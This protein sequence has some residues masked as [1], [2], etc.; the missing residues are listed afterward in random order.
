MGRKISK[1]KAAGIFFF[2]FQVIF[3]LNSSL[4]AQQSE[5]E[6]LLRV[7]I[8]A[9]FIY[10]SFRISPGGLKAV[11]FLEHQ[12]GKLYSDLSL[13]KIFDPENRLIEEK[14]LDSGWIFGDFIQDKYIVLEKGD[15]DY[16]EEVKVVDLKGE[17]ILSIK[18]VG[19][20]RLFYDLHGRELAVAALGSD[21][22]YAPSVVYD[23]NAR[24]EKFRLGPLSFPKND[25]KKSL[26]SETR[27][28]LPVGEDNL[29]V[30]GVGATVL[31]E[32]Y[33]RPGYIWK[34]DN[35]GGNIA[36]GKFLN[37]EYLALQYF[38]PDKKY[39]EGLAII[40][41]KDG[42]V[43]YKIE[44]FIVNNR[45]E[46]DL[47]PLVIHGLYLDEDLNLNFLSDDGRALKI[48]FDQQQKT[49]D[50]K[51]K[52][53]HKYNFGKATSAGKGRPVVIKGY[54][55]H[56]DEENGEVIIKKVKL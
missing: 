18:E 13:I 21:S 12:P 41:W 27:I 39:K 8:P 14:I 9:G 51:I 22:A 4:A 43:V 28:F 31:L 54:I 48:Y 37:E 6:E 34:I 23:L 47:P 52:R 55:F 50:E 38:V 46:K 19:S 11:C 1:I 3:L 29:F 53:A 16:L 44:N 32:K 40:R 7:E 24:R 2:I 45:R 35:I 56:A 17:E 42:Q 49:W 33:E 25:I 20:R 26:W 10:K 5:G 30:W 36:E 15:G